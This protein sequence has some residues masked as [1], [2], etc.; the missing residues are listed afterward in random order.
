[1]DKRANHSYFGAVDWPVLL[2]LARLALAAVFVVAGA[3]KLADLAGSRRAVE[4]F[5]VPAAAAGPLGLALPLAELAV[6]VLLLPA[7]SAPYAA[8]GGLV[9]LLAFCVA[10]G[11]ALARGAEPNCHCF[12]Q[13]HSAPA[14]WPTLARNTALAAVAALVAAAGLSDPG[15]SAVAWVGD[16]STTALMGA[17]LAAVVALFGFTAFHLLRQNGRLLLRL[18]ALE[19]QLADGQPAA[20]RKAQVRRRPPKGV[21]GLE[22]GSAAPDFALRSTAGGEETLGT[23]LSSGR[24]LL[25]VFTSVDCGPCRALKPDIAGWQRELADRL[26][27]APVSSGPADDSVA[28]GLEWALIQEKREVSDEY[29]A[30][31]T[32]AAV[33]VA[34]DG[35]IVSRVAGGADAIRD[36]VAYAA[37]AEVPA[38]KP[39]G[40]ELVEVHAI[41][42]LGDAAPAFRLS[43]LDGRIVDLADMRGRD[44]AL[45]FWNPGCGFCGRM[46]DDLR[47]WERS[48]RSG[49]P[50]LI[51]VS[52]GSAEQNRDQNLRSTILLDDGFATAEAFGASGTPMAVRIDPDGRVASGV[53]AGGQAVM[54]LL[55]GTRAEAVA[56]G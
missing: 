11:A 20:T 42:R 33:L 55:A 48:E 30:R 56:A 13:L 54:D 27:V 3:A 24:P 35:Q 19:A 16:L 39:A 9:L 25:L 49:A 14:G 52:R 37:D 21:G 29:D 41:P 17:A 31:G 53:A 12:G 2:L 8:F 36:L 22:L 26:T 34:P 15:P 38:A 50:A 46:L 4:G 18:D 47:A 7:A 28:D 45:L 5:G 10:I 6:G 40:L 1:V 44:V 43:D 51:V 23:L 32:P